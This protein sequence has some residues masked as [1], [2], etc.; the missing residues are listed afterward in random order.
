MSEGQAPEDATT[1]RSHV[2]CCGHW[3]PA[4]H[5]RSCPGHKWPFRLPD[6]PQLSRIC[7][8]S[9]FPHHYFSLKGRKK[10]SMTL[11]LNRSTKGLRAWG[12]LLGP[13][14]PGLVPRAKP[15]CNDDLPG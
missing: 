14:V 1:V 10:S 5:R 9:P 8:P 13:F 3:L 6:Y 4:E 15:G 11:I 2:H 7:F 12:T